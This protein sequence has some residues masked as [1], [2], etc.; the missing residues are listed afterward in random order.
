M[1]S[2]KYYRVD[3]ITYTQA[4]SYTQ[5]ERV[6]INT[7]VD[8][9]VILRSGFLPNNLGGSRVFIVTKSNDRVYNGDKVG[10]VLV[11]TIR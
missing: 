5:E 2:W 3:K 1:Q 8:G 6:P 11:W 7:G 4:L 10:T 9:I